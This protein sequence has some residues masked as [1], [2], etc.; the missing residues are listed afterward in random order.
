MSIQL[1]RRGEMSEPDVEILAGSA[2]HAGFAHG[3]ANG[4][5]VLIFL[6]NGADAK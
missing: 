2:L 6:G 1:L 3:C 4:C 5:I